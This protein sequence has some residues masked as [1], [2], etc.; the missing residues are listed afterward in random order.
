[1]IDI[2]DKSSC[3][4]CT[5]CYNICAH[6]AINMVEDNEGFVYPHVKQDLC[7][8][9]GACDKICP[10][11]KRDKLDVSCSALDSYVAHYSNNDDIWYKSSSGGVFT[12]IVDYVLENKGVVFGAAYN[13]RWEVEHKQATTEEEAIAFRGSKYVQS[14]LNN[15]FKLIKRY[16]QEDL[17]VLFSGTPCQVAGLKEYLRKDYNNLLTVD[18]LCHCVPSPRIFRDYIKYIQTKYSKKISQINMK[19]KT[20][21]WDK[22]QTPRIYFDDGSSLFNIDDTKL[23]EAIFY[24][25]IAVRPSCYECKFSNLNRVGDITIG[26]YW[27]VEKFHPEYNVPQGA[28]IVLL[29]NKKGQDAFA[30]FSKS[31]AFEKTDPIKALPSSLV[32]SVKPHPKRN[33]FWIDYERK[34]FKRIISKYFGM[35]FYG[36]LK[37]F[38]LN[39]FIKTI[40][41]IR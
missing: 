3:T 34:S 30:C 13:D 20:L 38:T 36:K 12:A 4:G 35:G 22:F 41:K 10:I 16:L 9:C 5:A 25:H 18:L 27:G 19:D 23:W 21:G 29:N 17:L 8:N 31:L 32:Y 33:Q 2:I 1:M 37:F 24:S 7:V 11:P 39:I 26:D 6:A 40:N 14:R 28:S 15:T